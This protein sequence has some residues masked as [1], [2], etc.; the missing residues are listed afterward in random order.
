MKKIAGFYFFTL[1]I[2]LLIMLVT[3]KTREQQRKDLL[4][5]Q[6]QV[7]IENVQN[8]YIN[9]L[10]S[11]T[12]ITEIVCN[13]SNFDHSNTESFQQI[14]STWIKY[15]P[16]ILGFNE[17]DTNGKIIKGFPVQANI[18]AM[19]KISQNFS[20][21]SEHRGLND[22]T[23]LSGPFQLF[24]EEA[25]FAIYNPT[26]KETKHT[27]WLAV[28]IS[29]EKF[30]NQ[31]IPQ[32]MQKNFHISLKDLNT[33]KYFIKTGEVTAGTPKNLNLSQSFEFNNRKLEI[34]LWPKTKSLTMGLP[35]LWPVFLA[36]IIASLATLSYWWWIKQR[37]SKER[38]EEL[39]QLLRLTIHDTA[40]SLTAIRGYLEIMKDDPTLVP[41]EKLSRHVNFI[42]DLLDQIKVMKQLSS[43]SQKWDFTSTSLLNIIIE[44]S[45]IHSDKLTHKK[46]LLNYS[47]EDLADISIKVNRALF[48]HSVLGNL[49][50]NAIKFSMN[51]G[52]I[53]IQYKNDGYNHIIDI[54]DSGLGID[55]KLYELIKNKKQP[56][57]KMGTSGESGSGFGLL[58][59]EQV[60]KLH[61]GSFEFINA[62]EG[63]TVARIRLPAD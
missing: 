28:V 40:S 60:I 61:N 19:G 5:R 12:S 9:F 63:G 51:G 59:V 53:S 47:P 14:Y 29:S 37:E 46:I 62:P 24:Q 43:S 4:T 22:K 38:L 45:E 2:A 8:D 39:N 21:F 58:I 32:H 1:S 33:D 6:A 10:K 30:F 42:I 13:L 34:S 48:A 27:G 23:W 15:Y 7:I 20:F 17:L 41:L 36:I 18:K 55:H 25:G 44:V 35:W 50:S 57:S 31:F 11:I 16:Y 3:H 49:I 56:I 54:T 26:Y 52:I